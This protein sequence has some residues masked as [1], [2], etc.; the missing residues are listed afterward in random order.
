MCIQAD[1]LVLSLMDLFQVVFDMKKEVQEA[2]K[3]KGDIDDDK[4]NKGKELP[5]QSKPQHC[6]T[7]GLYPQV[8]DWKLR[9]EQSIVDRYI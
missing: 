8:N 2:Q 5:Q 6:V 1:Y 4:E 9:N 3:Q 7:E